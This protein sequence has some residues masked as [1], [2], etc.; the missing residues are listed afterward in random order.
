M[1]FFLFSSLFPLIG[2][3]MLILQRKYGF[4]ANRLSFEILNNW[5]VYTCNRMKS[6][7]SS[8]VSSRCSIVNLRSPVCRCRIILAFGCEEVI[9]TNIARKKLC[10]KT[11][12]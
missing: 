9:I 1:L 3:L 4:N 7:Y 12:A 6:Q 5:I 11:I 2:L 10:V 8:S